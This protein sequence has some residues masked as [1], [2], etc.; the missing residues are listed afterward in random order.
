MLLENLKRGLAAA[1][2]A[3]LLLSLLPAGALAGELPTGG[4]AGEHGN[5]VYS[6]EMTVTVAVS[7]THLTLP[8]ICS[9]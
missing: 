7:Y 1:L 5:E 3:C 2:C 6:I 4:G 8:T 9:V